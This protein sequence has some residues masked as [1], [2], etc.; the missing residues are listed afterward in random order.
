[1][2]LALAFCADAAKELLRLKSLGCG[3][4]TRSL[5]N[6]LHNLPNAI[7]END[8]ANLEQMTIYALSAASPYWHQ[9]TPEFHEAFE[10]PAD[11]DRAEIFEL[12]NKEG[13]AFDLFS[14][15]A[16]NDD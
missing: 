12:I 6:A 8:L 16:R 4:A 13:F 2:R 11:L 1:M 7:K 9:L 10:K 15:E 3:A 5:G 14:D